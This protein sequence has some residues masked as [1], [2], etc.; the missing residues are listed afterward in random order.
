MA[1]AV[2]IQSFTRNDLYVNART[3]RLPYRRRSDQEKLSV[4]WEQRKLL[5][6]EI[7]FFTEFWNPQE[8]PKPLCVYAGAA[9]GTHI[10]LL[11]A[12][13][14][15]FTFHL[16]DPA[17]IK[18]TPS[19]SVQIFHQY[20]DDT[21]AAQ[22]A[23]RSDVFFVSDVLTAD[24]RQNQHAELTKRGITQFDAQ[25]K[26]I[27]DYRIIKEAL[28]AADVLTE[29][30]IW[31]DMVMQQTWTTIM[32]PAHAWLKGHFPYAGKAEGQ[33]ET[34]QYLTSLVFVQPWRG[35]TSTETRLKPVRDANG[36]YS[37]QDWNILEYEEWAFYHN[38]HERELAVYANPF[39][40]DIE[41]VDH[42]ELMNDYD[43]VA[44]AFIL[45][46][47]LEK[48]GTPE[49]IMYK[50][51]RR[52]SKLITRSLNQYPDPDDQI[53]SLS[54]RRLEGARSSTKRVEARKKRS[55][56][57]EKLLTTGTFAHEAGRNRTD[58][59]WLA[60]EPTL[61]VQAKVAGKA[62]PPGIPPRVI[63]A[64]ATSVKVPPPVARVP[65]PPVVRVPPPPVV[66]TASVQIPPPRV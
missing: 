30:Q 61:R 33:S 22:Y 16:Y 10:D 50:S 25:G 60:P 66:K 14:P 39:T 46:E 55:P 27:G 11:L 21:V 23:G 43:S 59:K 24:F 57:G 64:P 29:A 65:P 40:G 26:A 6:S 28:A 47:Y 15:Q 1:A 34:V 12:M 42:P 45:K 62:P 7:A 32:N 63:A 53:G 36:Q 31:G 13:F 19:P 20:F 58:T 2:P 35:Q 38:V 41:P 48:T 44:E 8:I 17:E 51:L 18:T 4:H 52:L 5:I 56:R 49:T 9:P 37:L 3:Q 54:Q